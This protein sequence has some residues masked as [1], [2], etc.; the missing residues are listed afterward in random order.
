MKKKNKSKEKIKISIKLKENS[1]EN[2]TNPEE[3]PSDTTASEKEK[4]KKLSLEEIIPSLKE[5]EIRT[6]QRREEAKEEPKNQIYEMKRFI[7]KTDYHSISDY[8]LSS[9]NYDMSFSSNQTIMPEQEDFSL[10][11]KNQNKYETAREK[12]KK[13]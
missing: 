5:N 9:N 4:F 12:G 8:K 11:Q 7:Q 13:W 10:N 1:P 6:V 3:K 2:K